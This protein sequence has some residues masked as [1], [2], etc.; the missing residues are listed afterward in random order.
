MRAPSTA[1][2]GRSTRRRRQ[3]AR[4]ERGVHGAAG[5]AMPGWL[6]RS[7]RAADWRLRHAARPRP[8][9]SAQLQRPQAAGFHSGLLDFQVSAICFNFAAASFQATSGSLPWIRISWKSVL[10]TADLPH[11]S[12]DHGQVLLILSNFWL[13]VEPMLRIGSAD[14]GTRS[15][16]VSTQSLC[17]VMKSDL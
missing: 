17:L 13:L 1:M 10:S 5:Y 11:T 15:A 2:A 6:R 16:S 7:W 14:V 8:G 9:L 12:D 4:I 3:A